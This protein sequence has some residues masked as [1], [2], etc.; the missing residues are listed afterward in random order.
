MNESPCALSVGQ[1]C[2][3]HGYS[4]VWVENMLPCFV[5]PEEGVALMTVSKCCPCYDGDATAYDY[6]DKRPQEV[7]GIKVKL[8]PQGA[9]ACP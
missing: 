9:P 3:D 7:C 5:M 4:F 1:R 8:G 6:N 2:M